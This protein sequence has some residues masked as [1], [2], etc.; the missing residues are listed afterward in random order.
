MNFA[1]RIAAAKARKD[2]AENAITEADKQEIADRGE[3]ARLDAETKAAERL[4]RDLDLDRRLDVAREKLGS[5][6]KLGTLAFDDYP[7]T[8]IVQHHAKA[9]AKWEKDVG[10][11]ASNKKIDVAEV[12]RSYAVTAVYDWNGTTDFGPSTV[13]GHA[14]IQHFKATPGMVTPIVNLA[15]KLAGR[16]AEER[17]S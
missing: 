13:N 1:E 7:D 17:K 9:H 11:S 16:F 5:S 15:S 10:D 14:L 3:L 6:I 12:Q 8:F 2:A 4:R